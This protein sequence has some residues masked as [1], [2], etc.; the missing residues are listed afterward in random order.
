MP[1]FTILIPPD[2]RAVLTSKEPLSD[3]ER[4][5]VTE[6]AKEWQA[7]ERSVLIVEDCDVIHVTSVALVDAD[8]GLVRAAR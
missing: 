1:R 4:A 3:D 7:L 6:L 8:E 2:G 5:R